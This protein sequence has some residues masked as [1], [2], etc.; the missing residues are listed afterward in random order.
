MLI[1]K[2]GEQLK[3]KPWNRLEYK[4]IDHLY[5]LFTRSENRSKL[6]KYQKDNNKDNSVFESKDVYTLLLTIPCT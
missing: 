2:R 5:S 6:I 4:K 1:E 3:W